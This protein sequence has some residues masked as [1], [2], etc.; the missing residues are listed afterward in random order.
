MRLMNTVYLV[1]HRVMARQSHGSLVVT[2]ESGS[3]R[4][5]LEAID[6][7]VILGG[8]SMTLDAV[9]ACVE[10]GVR[11]SCHQR[12]GRIKWSAAPP[13]SGNVKLRLSHYAAAESPSSTLSLSKVFV[14]A[15]LQSSRRVLK[16]W[17]RD[18]DPLQRLQLETRALRIEGSLRKLPD[19]QTGDHVRGLEGDGARSF[20]AGLG[21]VLS[22]SPMEFTLRNRRPPRDPVNAMLS[23]AYAMA[24]S[25]LTGALDAVGLDPQIGFLHRSRPGRPALALDLLEEMRPVIDRFVVG[26]VRRR[27]IGTDA[28]T[29][30]P[31]G[32]T[33]LSDDGRRQFLSLWEAHKNE[34]LVHPFLDKEVDRWAVPQVQATL[35]ARHLRGDLDVYPP[36]ILEA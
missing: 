33:F 17:A 10:R 25:E 6:H 28:F 11:V 13:T 29:V 31:G 2:N 3:Q 35:L 23:F 15:K 34:A 12:G 26:A 14:G 1:D 32:A 22:S 21:A 20:F 27:M 7:V 18:S 4:I 36:F 16:R 9:T 8:A 24:T 5:P 30:T 19:A